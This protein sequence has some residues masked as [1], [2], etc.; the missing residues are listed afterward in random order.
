MGIQVILADDHESLRAGFRSILESDADIEVISEAGNGGDTVAQVAALKPD[1][2]VMD[3]AMPGIN[4]VD[5]TREITGSTQGVKVLALSGHNDG[6]FVKGMLEAGARGYLLKDAA[7][8]ELVG[9]V[10]S[11]SARRWSIRSPTAFSAP[12]RNCM[13]AAKNSSNCSTRSR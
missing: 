2:V 9:A 13:R 1:V 8:E 10:K 6:F 7:V 3:V 4:G 12:C 11:T 5:A